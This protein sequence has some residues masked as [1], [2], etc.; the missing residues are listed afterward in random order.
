M[1]TPMRARGACPGEK[2]DLPRREEILYSFRAIE[3][4]IVR[5]PDGDERAGTGA[6][7]GRGGRTMREQERDSAPAWDEKTAHASGNEEAMA[8]LPATGGEPIL[9]TSPESED[10]AP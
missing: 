8:N 3:P 7:G 5:C 6:T 1:S 9:V 2:I 4:T 10:G